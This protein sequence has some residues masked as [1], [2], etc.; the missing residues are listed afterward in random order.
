MS[1][2]DCE[3]W[4]LDHWQRELEMRQVQTASHVVFARRSHVSRTRGAAVKAAVREVNRR[5][6][7]TAPERLARLL[8]NLAKHRRWFIPGSVR[9]HR[10][11]LSPS[12]RGTREK[13]PHHHYDHDHDHEALAHGFTSVELTLPDGFNEGLLR[14]WLSALPESVLRV[15]GIT[16]LPDEPDA[17]CSFQ[18]VGRDVELA[19]YPAAGRRRF[20]SR[21]I[22]IGPHL[23][24]AALCRQ[25]ARALQ[26]ESPAKPRR[27]RRVLQ[28]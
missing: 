1:L 27:A 10:L 26:E 14:A 17:L 2:V 24:G 7:T 19:R 12:Q 13:H 8:M 3:R 20:G 16:R 11:V 6:V 18:R 28:P 5:A 23:D 22:L 15:K 9:G 25:A 4:Q 21:A